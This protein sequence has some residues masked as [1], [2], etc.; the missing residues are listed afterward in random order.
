M[1]QVVRRSVDHQHADVRGRPC[2]R[3]VE[4]CVGA[5]QG[6]IPRS[7]LGERRGR[8]K[9]EDA[10][11]EER[12]AW[13]GAPSFEAQD[14]DEIS[15]SLKRLLETWPSRAAIHLTYFI[16]RGAL[17][18]SSSRGGIIH[19]KLSTRRS[20]RRAHLYLSR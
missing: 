7:A 4:R 18:C 10:C 15:S 16:V 5:S 14:S 2:V 17:L 9:A 12:Q 8:E 3:R 6:Q 1:P 11:G 20:E 13:H 19:A